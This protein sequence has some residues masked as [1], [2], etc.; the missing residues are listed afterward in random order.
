M[1]FVCPTEELAK[2]AEQVAPVTSEK[3]PLPIL[4]NLL[5]EAKADSI[6]LVASD[7]E[8]WV[9]RRLPA[10][11]KDTGSATVPGDL[12]L[13]VLKSLRN[14]GDVEVQTAANGSVKVTAPGSEYNLLSL[15]ALE[16][17]D[18]PEIEDP[19]KIT[20][21]TKQ[22]IE[23]VEKVA[24]AVAKD[25][26]RQSMRGVKTEWDGST[27]RMVAT[28]T[29]RLAKVEAALPSQG[30]ADMIETIVPLKAAQAVSRMAESEELDFY[31][32]GNR[33]K[34]ETPLATIVGSTITSPYPNYQRVIPTEFTRRWQIHV[35]ELK[36]ALR[37]LQ[38]LAV[39]AAG[40]VSFEMGKSS[41]GNDSL[42]ITARH[43]QYGE[44]REEI[45][46]VAEGDTVQLACNVKYLLDAIDAMGGD[47]LYIELT[48]PLRPLV[49]KPAEDKNYL[50]I[51]MP[52]AL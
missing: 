39:P 17:P 24:F 8:I 48:D 2:A 23:L 13:N 44:G 36:P 51:V 11:V 18:L 31:I 3:T 41:D 27:L 20:L 35:S 50:C 37:T 49:L 43:E 22:Y 21:P 32:A 47:N 16:F 19:A 26:A 42:I 30:M 28:D 9:E 38:P 29:H 1:H 4:T 52:M 33:V 7:L 14:R 15:S 46:V 40:K 6:R 10:L 5:I 25:E 12:F 45:G 34:Y